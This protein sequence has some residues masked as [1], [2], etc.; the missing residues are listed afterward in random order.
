M[1]KFIKFIKG[2]KIP[3]TV[4]GIIVM[5]LGVGLSAIP[6]PG[7]QAVGAKV[8]YTG[9]AITI[10]GLSFKATKLKKAE[11]GKKWLALTENERE[12]IERLRKKK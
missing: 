12:A 5:G 3:K 1:L 9:G 11:K 6:V 2:L 8:I 10:A 7:I 4:S